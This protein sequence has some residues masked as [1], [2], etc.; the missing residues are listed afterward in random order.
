[1]IYLITFIIIAASVVLGFFIL[2]QNPK[3]G[4]LSGIFGNA[5][6]QVMGVKQSGDIM[7]KGTWV[8]MSVIA[9]LCIISVMFM[10]RP[11]GSEDTNSAKPAKSAPAKPAAGASHT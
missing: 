8:L 9:G 7:E 11:A 6:S 4:G 10:Q 5:S 2:I 3:G 1:M